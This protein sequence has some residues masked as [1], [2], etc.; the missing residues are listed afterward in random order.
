MD[1]DKTMTQTVNTMLEEM[2]HHVRIETSGADALAAFSHNPTNFDLVIT[3]LGMPDISGLLLAEKLLRMRHDVPIVL[4]T[5]PDGEK[6][7][8]ARETGI[9]WFALKPISL[10]ALAET[11]RTALSEAA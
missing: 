8:K 4:L 7:S 5:G 1:G 6:Q 3:E 2:G 11:V 9:R 10:S